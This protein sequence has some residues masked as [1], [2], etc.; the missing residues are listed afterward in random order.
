MRRLLVSIA[1]NSRP[2]SD[3]AGVVHK[4]QQTANNSDTAGQSIL[5]KL[6]PLLVYRVQD[7]YS[8]LQAQFERIDK[9]H[10]S[11]DP[12][13]LNQLSSDL[14]IVCPLPTV[15][16]HKQFLNE[17]Y[18]NLILLRCLSQQALHLY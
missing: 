2:H 16:Q 3:N 13:A 18:R 17:L 10:L 7:L 15:L 6:L 8:N 5:F 4:F 12:L 9:T 14:C 11:F 1:K